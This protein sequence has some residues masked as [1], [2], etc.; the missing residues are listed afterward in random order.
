VPHA[1]LFALTLALSATAAAASGDVSLAVEFD[2]APIVALVQVQ[3]STFPKA[4]HS[5]ED[6]VRFRN[7]SATLLVIASWKGPYHAGATMRAIQPN[8]CGGYPCRTYPFQVGEIVLVF[9]TRQWGEPISAPAIR[10]PEAQTMTQLYLLSWGGEPN[11]RW[12]GP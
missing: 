9:A 4:Y 8:V 6:E 11:N 12:R 10:A 7:A 5:A 1:R 2:A 3:E